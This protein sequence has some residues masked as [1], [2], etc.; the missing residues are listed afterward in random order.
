MSN[1]MKETNI[2]KLKLLFTIVE[3]SKAEFYVD[4]LSQFNINSQ[5]VLSGMGTAKSEIRDLLGLNHHKAVIISVITDDMTKRILSGLEE[6]FKTIKK[7]KGVC[8]AVDFSSVLGVNTYRFL[9]D[10]R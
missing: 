7:G 1:V 10:N 8:F 4:Y 2:K 9:S 3:K 5:F 6:K